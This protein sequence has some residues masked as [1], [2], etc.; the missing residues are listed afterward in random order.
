MKNNPLVKADRK[1]GIHDLDNLKRGRVIVP[2][3][4]GCVTRRESYSLSSWRHKSSE[5]LSNQDI[6]ESY[7]IRVF[8]KIKLFNS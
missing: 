6:R 2:G 1:T 7:F 8:S 3:F 5:K 4:T